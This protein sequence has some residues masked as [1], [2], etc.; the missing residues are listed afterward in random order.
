MSGTAFKFKQF[1]IEQDR[2]AMKIGTDGI[3]LG[4]WVKLRDP[5]SILDIGAGTGIIA[6]M[7]AQRST[8]EVIDAIEI[9]DDAYEQCV[10][11]FENS[12]WGDRLFCYHASLDEFG[13]EMDEEKY[14]LIISNPPFFSEDF[15]SGNEARDLARFA[16][17]LPFEDLIEY[18]S[19]LLS[20]EGQFA[21][22]IPFSEENKFLEIARDVNL[23][24]NRITHVHGTKNTA[25]K[26]SLMQFSFSEG[27]VQENEL[28][29]EI[30][31]HE[32]T[33]DYIELVKDFYLKM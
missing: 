30:N 12:P 17:A 25:I 18:T 6:L 33:A 13:E 11:N 9:D 4:A 28:V 8:A 5:Y 15:K 27:E 19:T 3:L 22:I 26:R 2:C 21:V 10:D 24:P 16:D 20:N 14:D 23:F 31:R 7:M 32:Y 29:I 1:T